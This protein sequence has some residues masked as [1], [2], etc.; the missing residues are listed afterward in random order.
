MKINRLYCLLTMVVATSTFC[1]PGKA[2]TIYENILPNTTGAFTAEEIGNE[3]YAAGTAREVTQIQVGLSMQGNTGLADFVLRL[4]DNTGAGGAPG[5]L[6]WQSSLFQNV[7]LSGS[8][9]LVSFNVPDIIVPDVFTWTIQGFDETPVAV[10]Y[11]G[12]GSPSIGGNP[13][14]SW[15]GGPGQ[16]TQLPDTIFMS[17]IEAQ[18]VPDELN[19][20]LLCL[21][22]FTLALSCRKLQKCRSP[23]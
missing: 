6:L 20:G 9:Q 14:Y 19:T 17:R 8:A 13:S 21:A 22:L 11:D 12:A 7:P 23:V 15:F 3:V 1:V 18:T 10:E 4:Y 2:V 16:W 5:G